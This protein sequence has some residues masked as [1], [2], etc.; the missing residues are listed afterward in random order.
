MLF[1]RNQGVMT[2]NVLLKIRIKKKKKPSGINV[3]D[4]KSGLNTASPQLKDK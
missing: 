4:S 3:P 2:S 1:L